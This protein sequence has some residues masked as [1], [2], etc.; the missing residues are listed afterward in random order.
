[1]EN[2]MKETNDLL[3]N[4]SERDLVVIRTFIAGYLEG[5]YH[6]E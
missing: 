3:A 2:L 5:K 1:M 4:A 6:F